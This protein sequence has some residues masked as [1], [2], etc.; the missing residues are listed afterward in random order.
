M[1]QLS[2]TTTVVAK[3]G[4]VEVS[5]A[6]EPAHNDHMAARAA[7]SASEH[8]HRI[9]VAALYLGAIFAVYMLLTG[10][11]PPW[12]DARIMYEVS[13]N[14]TH[15]RISIGTE[16][17]P[18]SHVGV[19][20]QPAVV[21]LQPD[22]TAIRQL[23][24]TTDDAFQRA[25]PVCRAGAELQRGHPLAAHIVGRTLQ[26]ALVETRD[27]VGL[28]QELVQEGG[29][30]RHV[31]C[32][33]PKR[34]KRALSHAMRKQ[35]GVAPIAHCSLVHPACCGEAGFQYGRSAATME[36]WKR[37]PA[38]ALRLFVERRGEPRAPGFDRHRTAA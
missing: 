13:K 34:G 15:G 32:A 12:G 23:F 8:S 29:D 28:L 25:R 19:D 11:E 17:P 7:G 20:G 33:P 37:T 27:P 16:W 35:A 2:T 10:R 5:S 18:M 1:G 26:A 31:G 14:I 3:P 30:H 21:N 38:Q 24:G 22:M 36:R 4:T 6:S 9:K